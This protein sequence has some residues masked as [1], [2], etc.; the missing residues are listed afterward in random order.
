[1]Y[2]LLSGEGAT[3]LGVGTRHTV[4]CEG[5]D[6]TPG[7][8]AIMVEQIVERRQHYSIRDS[9]C[10]GYVS[11]QHLSSCAGVFKAATKSLGLPGKK[12]PKETRYFF[13]NARA[14]SQIAKRKAAERRD[15]VVA[16]LFRDADGTASAGRGLWE[17]KCQSMLDGFDQEGFSKGVPMIPKPKSEAWFICALQRNSYQRCETLEKRSGNDKSPNSLKGELQTLLG[18]PV[19]VELLCEKLLEKAVDIR[20][21]KMPS[22]NS[23]RDRLESVI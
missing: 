14:L 16:I 3:D 8:M 12:R 4:I 13:N 10:C 7:P 11:E 2:F 15:E 20:K 19:S 5:R 1:M 17:E 6:Y 9:G 23:F 22:F 21:I 18:R